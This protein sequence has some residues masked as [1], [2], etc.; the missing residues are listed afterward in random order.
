MG[1]AIIP[2]IDGDLGDGSLLFYPNYIYIYIYC[3]YTY[4]HFHFQHNMKMHFS[5]ASECWPL[6]KCFPNQLMYLSVKKKVAFENHM[7][8]YTVDL[9]LISWIFQLTWISNCHAY[10]NYWRI[11]VQELLWYWLHTHL[12]GGFNVE[13]TGVKSGFVQL[14]NPKSP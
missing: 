9:Q 12:I 11:H 13:Q 7:E 3:N 4:I 6:L 1:M 2:P 14:G 10:S 8:K 5:A